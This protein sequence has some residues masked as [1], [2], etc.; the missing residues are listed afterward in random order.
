MRNLTVFVALLLTGL[1]FA[2]GY[3]PPPNNTVVI[4]APDG[5]VPVVVTSLPSVTV[6]SMPPVTTPDGGLPVTWAGSRGVYI[7]QTDGGVQILEVTGPAGAPV[8]TTVD[9]PITLGASSEAALRT[10]VTCTVGRTARL[11][12]PITTLTRLPPRLPDGGSYTGLQRR[13]EISVRNVD[14]KDP[15]SCQFGPVDAGVAPNCSTSG[16]G[17][18]VYA[19]GGS[20]RYEV[21]EAYEVW[22]VSCGSNPSP[23]AVVEVTEALCA[24]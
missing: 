8:S 2:Q 6:A 18:T 13:T 10:P 14:S 1:A 17:D 22:C 21:S 3:T 16:W 20:V 19:L 11:D 23:G 12:V 9:N 7:V 4:R 5:G 15:A 24:P